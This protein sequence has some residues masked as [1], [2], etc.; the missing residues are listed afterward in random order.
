M[1]HWWLAQQCGY[2]PCQLSRTAIIPSD[3]EVK[4][5][6]SNEIQ[7][8]HGTQGH[9]ASLNP[10]GRKKAPTQWEAKALTMSGAGRPISGGW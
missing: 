10:M 3:R 2:T 5:L 4:E 8:P 7:L 9:Y 1:L 6:V